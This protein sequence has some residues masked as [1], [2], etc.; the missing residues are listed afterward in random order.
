M[1]EKVDFLDAVDEVEE[2]RT[3]LDTLRLASPKRLNTLEDL[4]EDIKISA[5]AEIYLD[6]FDYIQGC[7]LDAIKNIRTAVEL[8]ED[9][10]EEILR[11]V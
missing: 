7:A 3:D 10:E 6:D 8:L 1:P 9:L 4:V 11:K 5:T 2:T